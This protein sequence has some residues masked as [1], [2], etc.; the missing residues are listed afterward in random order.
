[1]KR[2]THLSLF[3][4]I[5]GL[6]LAAEAAGF[7]TV[8]QCEAADFPT[9]IL[10]RH[11]PCVPRWRDIRELT[12]ESFY[13]K[14]GRWTVDLISGGF[15]CQPVS[16]AGKRR[17]KA[18]D[19][20]LW[21]EMLRV[22][23]EL[24]PAWVLGENVAGIISMALDDCITDLEN[25]GYSVWT[26]LFPA[27]AVEAPHRRDR[28]AILAYSDHIGC[29]SQWTE[30]QIQ[31]GESSSF[32]SG[33][34]LANSNGTGLQGKQQPEA[35]QTRE[36]TSESQGPI[37]E[38]REALAYTDNGSRIVRRDRELQSV[39][40]IGDSRNDFSGGTAEY[41]GGKRRT[42]QSGVGRGVNGLS[43]WL[44]RVRAGWSDGSWEAGIPRIATGVPNKTQ[45]LK[46]LGN[47][48]VPAQ[49][50]PIFKAIMETYEKG[51]I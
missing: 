26:L 47:A 22:V 19:R 51:E 6:D 34:A 20:F 18:D 8:G 16:L 48:V 11:W 36:R 33:G 40:R 41:G 43:R 42:T 31:E 25:Q 13:E 17:G 29:R 5:G 50:Y 3:S 2:M 39:E 32:D 45:R 30:C 1:M 10:E 28:V 37:S 21:P 27:C 9:R 38:C 14:T 12:R 24:R 4:G 49:F 46:A 44:D 7:E 23:Q 15:P 35:L